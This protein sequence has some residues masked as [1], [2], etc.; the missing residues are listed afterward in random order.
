MIKKPALR[1]ETGSVAVGGETDHSPERQGHTPRFVVFGTNV[2]GARIAA[3]T[4]RQALE[5]HGVV[6]PDVRVARDVANVDLAFF[7]RPIPGQLA[8]ES[9][10]AT[11]TDERQEKSKALAVVTGALGR[12]GLWPARPE[13]PPAETTVPD[14]VLVFPEM[15]QYTS[16]GTGMTIPTPLGHIEALCAEHGVPLLY[17]DRRIETP[18]ELSQDTAALL[19]L[20]PVPPVHQ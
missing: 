11:T 13:T 14:G 3:E 17:V 9:P 1:P 6:G 16:T 10:A 12:L 4:F 20:P 19:A 8:L 5:E 15:R 2:G 7:N 18:S